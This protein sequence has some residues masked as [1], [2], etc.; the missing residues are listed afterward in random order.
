MSNLTPEVE[1]VGQMHFEG[2]IIPHRWYQN[3]THTTPG[4]HTKPHLEAILILS[5]V[6]YWYRPVVRRPL[7]PRAARHGPPTVPPCGYP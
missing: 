5:D 7:R 6:V 3:I 4:G 2:N 1:A